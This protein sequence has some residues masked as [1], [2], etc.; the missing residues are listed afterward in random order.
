MSLN[1]EAKAF[2][3]PL[4]SILRCI[5]G[6]LRSQASI[7][8][9]MIYEY[10][11]FGIHF[12]KIRNQR[13]M[14][15]KLPVLP[16]QKIPATLKKFFDPRLSL[17]VINRWETLGCRL[18]IKLVVHIDQFGQMLAAAPIDRER[19]TKLISAFHTLINNHSFIN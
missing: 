2:K 7:S 4:A 17:Y 11:V 9:P 8:V 13:C 14:P 18:G 3:P 19:T 12:V 10:Y 1:R 5:G 6:E 16:D 15:D